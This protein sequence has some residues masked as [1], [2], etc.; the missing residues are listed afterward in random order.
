MSVTTQ[1]VAIWDEAGNNSTGVTSSG[2]V[3]TASQ[4]VTATNTSGS[5]SGSGGTGNVNVTTDAVDQILLTLD[6]RPNTAGNDFEVKIYSDSG[7]TKLI[8]WIDQITDDVFVLGDYEALAL[9]D[10]IAY[11][12]IVNNHA[13][14][15]TFTISITV[16][17]RA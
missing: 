7:R 11:F 2:A 14:S 10:G 12:T 3:H 13:S 5:I 6:V 17:V 1:D 16:E 4:N 8:Y 9:P 15:R